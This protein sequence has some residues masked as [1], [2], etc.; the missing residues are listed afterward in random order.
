MK[1]GS[2]RTAFALAAVVLGTGQAA[3]ELVTVVSAKS[4]VTT[5]T[6]NQV[7]D[8]FLGKVSR[9]PDGGP[10]VPI[11]QVEGAAARDEF[12]RT[13]AGKSPGQMNAHWSKII[14]T[15]RGHPPTEA[16]NGEA[17]KRLLVATPGAIGYLDR[18]LVD[19]ALRVLVAE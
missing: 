12:Y 5:L 16:A 3:A 15:G 14:F 10:A 8:I 6:R 13:L 17:L 18:S 1:P 11:D 7:V 9:F 2:I 4:A 19:G